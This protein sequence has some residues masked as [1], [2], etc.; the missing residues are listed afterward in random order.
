MIVLKIPTQIIRTRSGF[1]GLDSENG[2][3]EKYK[4]RVFNIIN[5]ESIYRVFS[6]IISGCC[7]SSRTA[8][9]NG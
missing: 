8:I 5:T 1:V 4:I 6:R 9:V 2:T 7:C 3:L